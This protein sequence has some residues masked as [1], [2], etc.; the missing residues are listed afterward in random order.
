VWA[1][2]LIVGVVLSVAAMILWS[3]RNATP[4]PA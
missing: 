3:R 2:Y 4:A 1:A